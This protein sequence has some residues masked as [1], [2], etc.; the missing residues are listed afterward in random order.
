[1]G[2]REVSIERGKAIVIT[3]GRDSYRV[4][5][6]DRATT[7]TAESLREKLNSG[8]ARALS[9]PVF[10]FT[11]KAGNEYVVTGEMPS[12]PPGDTTEERRDG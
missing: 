7:K 12:V 8:K 9:V 4:E 11:D 10:F 3:D 6:A 1:M 2:I 5:V